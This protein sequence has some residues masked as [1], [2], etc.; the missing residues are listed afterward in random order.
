MHGRH[1]LLPLATKNNMAADGAKKL[2]H[3]VILRALKSNT[4]N[5]S[6]DNTKIDVF[7]LSMTKLTSLTKLSAKN[8]H[9]TVAGVSPALR[10]LTKVCMCVCALCSCEHIF[11]LR[12]INLGCNRLSCL[13]DCFLELKELQNIH[14]FNNEIAQLDDHI[15]GQH[16]V[17]M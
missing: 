15:L 5:L 9:L 4:N 16:A 14:L 8:N 11:Q 3:G 2:D 7:P 10:G 13:P 6:L 12:V 1:L 17:R